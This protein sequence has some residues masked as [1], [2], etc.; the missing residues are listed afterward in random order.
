MTK[1]SSSEIS[2]GRLALIFSAPALLILAVTVL[3]PLAYAIYLSF[4]RYNLKRAKRPFAGFRNY[5]KI[6]TDDKF[7]D[8]LA[9]SFI[10]A[11]SAV[12]VIPR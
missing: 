9:T 7:W 5:E 3:V 4:H 12:A 8:S 6:L 11:V 2:Q 10:F 1:N